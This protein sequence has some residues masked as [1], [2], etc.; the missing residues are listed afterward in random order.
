M[1]AKVLF[2]TAAVVNKCARKPPADIVD[3]DQGQSLGATN[4]FGLARVLWLSR[5]DC[6]TLEIIKYFAR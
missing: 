6:P 1:N 3:L 4:V 2:R 5:V